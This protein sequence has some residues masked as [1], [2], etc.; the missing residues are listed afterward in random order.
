MRPFPGDPGPPPRRTARGA[1]GDLPTAFRHPAAAAQQQHINSYFIGSEDAVDAALQQSLA[2]FTAGGR[3]HRKPDPPKH[4]AVPSDCESI[5]TSDPA[6]ADDISL[7]SDAGPSRLN[8]PDPIS[9]LSQPITPLMLATPGSPSAISDTMSVSF[10]EDVASQALSMSQ[11]LEPMDASEMMDSGSAPQLVMPSIKMPSRR[12]FTDGGKRLGRLKVLVAGDSGVGKTSLIKALV[13]SCEHIVHVD[14]IAPQSNALLSQSTSIRRGRSRSSR[15]QTR[16]A[17]ISE[18]FASTKPYPEWWSD[19]DDFQLLKRRKI[20]DDTILDR[21][22]C[23]ID[24]PGYSDGASSME[25]ITPVIRY[26]ESQF[27]KVQSNASPDAEMLNMLGGDGG[28]QV[29]L[30]FYLVQKKLKPADI[31]YLQLLASLTN[32]I[33]LVAKSDN[34]TPEDV[35]Q[36]KLQIR[37]ELMGAGVRPFSFT[38][39]STAICGDNEPKYPFA[40]SST[41]GSDHDIMDA[42]L[43]MSPDYVQPLMQSELSNVVDQ[44]FCENGASWLRH[45]AAKKFIQW[46]NAENSSRPKALYEP[47]GLPASP[48]MPLVATGSLSSPVGATA[49]YSLARIADHTQREERLAQIRL[50]NWASELQRSLANERAR[51]DALARGERAIWLT[52]KIHECVQDGE[53][54]PWADRDRSVSRPGDRPGRKTGRGR[55]YST[56]TTQHQ[57]PLGLLHVA[58]RLKANGWVALE[59]LGGVGILGGAAVWLAGQEWPIVEWA[60]YQWSAFRGGGK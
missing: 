55:Y 20:V 15:I 57:D 37:S 43:L 14:P 45:A 52:E 38:L 5:S 26:V 35:A 41:P 16:T 12:P 2:S 49:Q 19:L 17:E 51:Y 13:Q 22:I 34:M 1:D 30:V 40:I 11:D 60:V 8:L 7:I 21:N 24:T 42:S 28:S 59:I 4:S 29:D 39:S 58:A 53:L 9:N 25:S 32:V 31:K 46:K 47:M 44:V 23:F 6:D 3:D 56:S 48:P 18:I 50:A 10:S 54:V 33:P 36:T 27:E